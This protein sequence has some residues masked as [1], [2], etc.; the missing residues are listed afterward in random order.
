MLSHKNILSDFQAVYTFL[1]PSNTYRMLSLLP[2]SHMFEQIAE[3]F[4]V[5]SVGASI[6]YVDS[7]QPSTIFRAMREEGA[8]GIPLVPQILALFLLES[9]LLGLAGGIL[10]AA[11]GGVFI[12]RFARRGIEF[13]APG[14]QIPIRVYPTVGP[15]YILFIS[16]PVAG[17]LADSTESSSGSRR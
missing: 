2:L 16:Y 12:L 13:V 4:Y 17:A 11:A 1:P 7:L 5:L 6:I 14:S 8:T 3:L 15:G 10:G 9:A